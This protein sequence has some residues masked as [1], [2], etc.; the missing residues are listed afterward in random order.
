MDFPGPS[1]P[2]CSPWPI[3]AVICS[4]GFRPRCRTL[5]RPLKGEMV[6]APGGIE[7]FGWGLRASP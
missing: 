3:C 1:P 6:W 7:S 4:V 5:S 2:P